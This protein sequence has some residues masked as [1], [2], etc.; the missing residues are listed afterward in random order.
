MPR[1]NRFNISGIDA[2]TSKRPLIS[3]LKWETY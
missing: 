1:L 2:Y 3:V